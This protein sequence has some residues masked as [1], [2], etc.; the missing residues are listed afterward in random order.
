MYKGIM[1]EEFD[2][3]PSLE[4]V[5]K[6]TVPNCTL[7]S[8]GDGAG[9]KG[10]GARLTF[11]KVTA[12]SDSLEDITKFVFPS[13]WSVEGGQD[14]CTAVLDMP[15]P[16]TPTSGGTCFEF[17]SLWNP[18][19]LYETPV[20][21]S[22][23]QSGNEYNI[24]SS[25]WITMSPLDILTNVALDPF[26]SFPSTSPTQ[27]FVN[28]VKPG[29][30]FLI[31]WW[32]NVPNDGLKEITDSASFYMGTNYTTTTEDCG[33]SPPTC[34]HSHN[35]S[36]RGY[37]TV[38][39]NGKLTFDHGASFQTDLFYDYVD[40]RYLNPW[41]QIHYTSEVHTLFSSGQASLD[42]P[43]GIR[44]EIEITGTAAG[45]EQ[46]EAVGGRLIGM[47]VTIVRICPG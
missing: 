33:D 13:S 18:T 42:N 21:A 34:S 31:V 7:R 24:D 26:W 29:W 41:E 1:L 3:D 40:F 46:A 37:N 2:G 25:G 30:Y 16:F 9:G 38:A 17:I 45:V 20:P 39:Y 32:D 14:S 5:T 36:A 12:G 15:Y 6:I 28:I 10:R 8:Y 11:N 27:P 43:V 19:L 22:I 47:R 35:V 23:D 4:D 44:G